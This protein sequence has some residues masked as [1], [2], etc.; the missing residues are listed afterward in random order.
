MNLLGKIFT[1]IILV[2]R[3]LFMG[4]AIM[5]YATHKNWRDIAQATSNQLQQRTAEYDRLKSEYN[6]LD[7]QLTAE[8]ESA[9]QQVRKL[10]SERVALVET[11]T[12]IQSELDQL[13]Q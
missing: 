12:T 1:F 8:L 3:I 2:M 13:R 10:E 9:Q 11:N 5:V 4:M 7:D 6:R